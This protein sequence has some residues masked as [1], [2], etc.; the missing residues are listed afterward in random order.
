MKLYPNL[1]NFNLVSLQLTLP[2]LKQLLRRLR[3]K[4]FNVIHDLV[5]RFLPMILSC[6]YLLFLPDSSCRC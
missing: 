4:T 1:A 3:Q 5:Q 2:D 6:L